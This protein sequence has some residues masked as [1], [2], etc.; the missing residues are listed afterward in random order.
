MNSH[1]L[2]Y[3]RCI[4]VFSLY[5][6]QL[7]NECLVKALTL[8]SHDFYRI[9]IVNLCSFIRALLE[10]LN[11]LCVSINL[12]AQQAKHCESRGNLSTQW[13][14]VHVDRNLFLF[15]A[16]LECRVTHLYIHFQT[17]IN[18]TFSCSNF[19]GFSQ[20]ICWVFIAK[21][22]PDFTWTV[23]EQG[24]LMFIVIFLMRSFTLTF[25]D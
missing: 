7:I 17:F 23:R 11:I 16:V 24:N 1:F 8:I 18:Q 15:E 13:Y 25:W 19:I 10:K 5:W 3:I 14:H 20:V 22:L 21:I 2:F 12:F 4:C 6:S 9:R